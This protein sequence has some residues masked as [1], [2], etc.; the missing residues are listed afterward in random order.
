MEVS[1]AKLRAATE[2]DVAEALDDGLL[3]LP[4]DS[5]AEM[6][7]FY[8]RMIDLLVGELPDD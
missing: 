5:A 3:A 2:D 4:I 8:N 7:E 6:L 1:L